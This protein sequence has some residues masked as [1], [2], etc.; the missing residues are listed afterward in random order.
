MSVLHC[1]RSSTCPLYNPIVDRPLSLS[2]SLFCYSHIFLDNL[3]FARYRQCN[4]SL[5][6]WNGKRSECY[7]G[8][9][10][11]GCEGDTDRRFFNQEKRVSMAY[12]MSVQ[13]TTEE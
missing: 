4:I 5:V 12:F 7:K 11:L 8:W 13:E 6:I 9:N 2:A 1:F 10:D 3:I